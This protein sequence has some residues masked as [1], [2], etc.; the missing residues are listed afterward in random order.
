MQHASVETMAEV[1]KEKGGCEITC[2]AQDP[3]Y[4][5][6]DKEFL[7]SI[8]ITPVNDPKGFLEVDSKTLVF[9]ASPDVPVR[10]IIIDIQ[11]PAAMLWNTVRT[12]P[13]KEKK[14]E[15]EKTTMFGIDAYLS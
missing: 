15:W 1:L 8:G 11:H 4:S 14:R 6:V 12:E 10:E 3:A 7:K 9:S 2:F 13:E 5:D